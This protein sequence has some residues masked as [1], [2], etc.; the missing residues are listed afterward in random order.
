MLK[1]NYRILIIII[2]ILAALAIFVLPFK[3]PYSIDSVAKILPAQQWVLSRGND[4]EVL[5]STVNHISGENNSYQ[6][7]SF[8][9]GESIILNL[10]P[11]LNNGDVVSKGDT[12]GVIYSS[13]QQEYLLQ[14]NGELRVLNASLKASMSGVKKTEVRE[15]E[16]RLAV[17][18]S[19]VEKQTKIVNRLNELHKNEIISR[20]E[21]Q[22][23]A[24]ELSILKKAVNV[25][26]A[27]L[28]S[29]LSGEK[30]EEINMLNE[31][32]KATENEIS[33]LRREVD[34][35]NLIITPFGGRI[36]KPFSNDTL[37]VLSNFDLGVAWIPVALEEA[38]NIPANG[39]VSYDSPF[40]ATQLLGEVHMT[41]PVMQLIDGKQ[42]ITVLATVN[43]IS[44]DFVSGLLTPAKINCDPVSLPVYLKRNLLN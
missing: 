10:N 43:A 35:Q 34:T 13:S 26:Q 16:H 6:L 40:F 1:K 22:T 32:I 39:K 38:A 31:K 3:I 8:E 4:G 27:E 17:A 19:E 21:Y 25:R 2:I 42:C 37:L 23:A 28:E 44:N 5:T 24:D 14:L 18:T 33:F 41:Q 7:T 30:D 29:S 36:D 12:L 9:R 15:A 20:E 11:E